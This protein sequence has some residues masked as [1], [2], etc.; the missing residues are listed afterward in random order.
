MQ[1]KNIAL[2]LCNTLLWGVPALYIAVIEVISIGRFISKWS[3]YSQPF[4]YIGVD[5]FFLF[6]ALLVLAAVLCMWMGSRGLKL[7]SCVYF[8]ALSLFLIPV[9]FVSASYGSFMNNWMGETVAHEYSSILAILA[10]PC[11]GILL[12]VISFILY[13]RKSK[14]ES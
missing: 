13:Y 8:F 3:L 11:A 14:V 5:I 9:S 1:K 12:S 4:S 7:T 6:M 2:A 10:F